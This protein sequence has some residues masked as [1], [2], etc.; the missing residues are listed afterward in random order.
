MKPVIWSEKE[1]DY[2]KRFVWDDPRDVTILGLFCSKATGKG[3]ADT[4][5]FGLIEVLPRQKQLTFGPTV[6]AWS[7]VRG[8]M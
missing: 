8:A 1:G 7:T 5:E 3:Q 6:S 4:E 2:Y